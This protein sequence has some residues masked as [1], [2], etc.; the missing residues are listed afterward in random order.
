MNVYYICSED[1]F[2]ELVIGVFH[3]C[4]HR[5]RAIVTLSTVMDY[6]S[7]VS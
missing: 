5:G 6:S 1:W 7:K 3:M 4:S 2:N